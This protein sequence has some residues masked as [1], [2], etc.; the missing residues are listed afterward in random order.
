MKHD[1]SCNWNIQVNIFIEIYVRSSTAPVKYLQRD[2]AVVL[3]ALCE[4]DNGL[5]TLNDLPLDDS[6]QR[7]SRTEPDGGS[8]Q[9]FGPKS[10]LYPVDKALRN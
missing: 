2:F 5:D 7:K 6:T 1:I 8:A 4:L 10:L 9:T 3:I